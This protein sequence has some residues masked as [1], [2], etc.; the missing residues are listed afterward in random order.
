MSK[1]LD[2]TVHMDNNCRLSFGKFFACLGVVWWP[3]FGSL[4]YVRQLL[5]VLWSIL[6]LFK[7]SASVWWPPVRRNNSCLSCDQS[8]ICLGAVWWP[9][10]GGL[11]YVR[12]LLSALPSRR[13][14]GQ[15][16]TLLSSFISKLCK[17]VFF[18]L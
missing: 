6:Y 7:S 18:N 17:Y 10:F 8:F 12:Q 13:L 16:F 2:P 1:S 5:S 14:C 3:L 4:Q 15:Y 9:L 11:Q